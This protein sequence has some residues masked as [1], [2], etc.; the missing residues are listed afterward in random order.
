MKLFKKNKT[1]G[2]SED[3]KFQPELEKKKKSMIHQFLTQRYL[4]CMYHRYHKIYDDKI[5]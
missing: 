1:F 2:K 4:M 3:A 5:I